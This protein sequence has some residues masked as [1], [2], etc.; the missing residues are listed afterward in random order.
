MPKPDQESGIG[1]TILNFVITKML[2]LMAQKIADW[3]QK[4]KL[5]KEEE[6]S[7]KE[8]TNQQ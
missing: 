8:E 2:I 3:W 6:V 7:E 5:K 1:N 4:R